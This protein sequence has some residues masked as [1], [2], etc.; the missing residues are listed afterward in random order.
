MYGGTIFVSSRDS[1]SHAP[2]EHRPPLPIGFMVSTAAQ[3]IRSLPYPLLAVG[4][5]TI[6]DWLFLSNRLINSNSILS[7]Q[8]LYSG[9]L[10]LL[11]YSIYKTKSSKL[12]L[13]L[14]VFGL[15]SCVALY[16]TQAQTIFKMGEASSIKLLAFGSLFLVAI[17]R[18]G[19]SFGSK[20]ACNLFCLGIVAFN[21][22][23]FAY[24]VAHWHS[25]LV[26]PARSNP[27]DS[28]S[29]GTGLCLYLIASL[30]LDRYILGPRQ[31][32]GESLMRD[33]VLVTSSLVPFVV[34]ASL[35]AVQ[36]LL[37]VTDSPAIFSA[38]AALTTALGTMLAFLLG[39]HT[40]EKDQKRIDHE[41]TCLQALTIIANSWKPG[42]RKFRA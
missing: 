2:C 22:S 38:G 31:G 36:H 12:A 29:P 18:N 30:Y 14:A 20:N 26:V 25:A 19:F 4:V 21:F 6:I 39:W 10:A 41:K 13:Q 1:K 40:W 15:V 24:A 9:L 28:V 27:F 3:M 35:I 17:V 37:P 16:A 8:S 42:W 32:E 23:L 11:A 34:V 33:Y 5:L 7:G